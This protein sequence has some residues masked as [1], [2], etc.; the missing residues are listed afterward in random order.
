MSAKGHLREI[1]WQLVANDLGLERG[2][3]ANLRW[4]RFRRA[5]GL[6]LPNQR[7]GGNRVAN[8]NARGGA[9]ANGIKKASAGKGKGKAAAPKKGKKGEGED[10]AYAGDEGT[11]FVEGQAEVKQEETYDGA[12]ENG[13]GEDVEEDE[14][15]EA[16]EEAA[17]LGPEYDEMYEG[18]EN[19][20]EEQYDGYGVEGEIYGDDGYGDGEEA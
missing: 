20:E 6:R 14:F 2:Q 19:G 8:A 15:H 12:E 5:T 17:A 13:L 4:T 9:K 18:T 10:E 3:A 1:N 7:G 16:P 11:G